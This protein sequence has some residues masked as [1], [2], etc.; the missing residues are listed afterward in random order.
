MIGDIQIFFGKVV[1]ISDDLKINRCR[2]SID[3]LTDEIK[4]EELPWYFPWYGINY[5]PIKND[6][7]SVIVFD[8]NFVTAFYGKKIDLIDLNLD[9]DDYENYLEIFKRSIDDKNIQLSY[10][11]STGIEF[12][13]DKTKIQIEL[14]KLSYFVESNSIIITKNKIT[15]GDKNQQATILGDKGVQQMQ[16]MITHQANTITE[17]MK[18]FN[19]ISVSCIT[20]FTAPI[21]AALS[22]LIPISQ[23]KLNTENSKVNESSK[24]IQSSKTFIE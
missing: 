12:I 22:P 23:T 6:V 11:K 3:G 17:M 19:A 1:D 18:L 9:K 13:N 2:I 4:T 10:K 15:L 14:D 24:I 20:P 8:S 16:D 21:K 5:L 7:V